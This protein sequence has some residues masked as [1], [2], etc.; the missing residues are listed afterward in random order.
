MD[1]NATIE[2][3][4]PIIPHILAVH[5]LTGCDTVAIYHDIG[6]GMTLRVLRSNKYSISKVGNM[7][8]FL[9]GIIRQATQFLRS[10]YGHP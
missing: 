10:C 4:L 3:N 7:N 8:R 2:K 1:I 6:E 5:G 9:Q